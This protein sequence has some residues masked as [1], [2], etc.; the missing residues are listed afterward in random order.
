M[1]IFRKSELLGET[2]AGM[3]AR[4]RTA[5]DVI[6]VNIM[7]ADVDLNIVYMNHALR[8]FLTR[9]ET[10]IRAGLPA[11]DMATVIGSNID[12][13]HKNP[14]HQRRML[15]AMTAT[16]RTSVRIGRLVFGL[17]VTPL[18]DAAGRRIGTVVEWSDTS[19]LDHAGQVAAINRAQAVAEF[20]M[21]GTVITANA[22]F[23][24]ATGY[25]L[26]EIQGRHHGMFVDA[27]TRAGAEYA[28]LW[29]RLNQGAH[30]AGQYR[31]LG[32]QGREIWL[33]ASYT[34]ILDLTN[35]P[36]KVVKYA[37]DLT[38]RRAALATLSADVKERVR[39]LAAS[40]TEL[41]ATAESLSA[42][43]TQTSSQSAAMAGA[44]GQ[45]AVSVDEISRQLASSA[46]VVGRAVSETDSSR[47]QVSELVS[48]AD[49]IGT[50]TNVIAQIAGQTNLLALNATIEAARAGEAGK[51]FA[52]V[53]SEVKSL[54]DQTARATSEIGAQVNGI[55]NSSQSTSQV[56]RQIAGTIAK[57]NE[58]TTSIS[59]AV[60]RQAVAT[61][62]VTQHIEGVRQAAAETGRSS[63]TL[64]EV[65]QDIAAQAATLEKNISDFVAMV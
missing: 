18:L 48:T 26:D 30:V 42:A 46:Q 16:H 9:F 22:H 12:I 52:V 58:I 47:N 29:E 33:Q 37:T 36:F 24:A 62:D 57:V 32:K 53:A 60:E 17:S 3:S 35:R 28:E 25:T 1:R 50:V 64:R 31:R 61:R 7:I 2:G 44:A 13:F 49:K 23:L 38:A 63:A 56:M 54:A 15:A 59:G 14:A 43:A 27:E 4:Q 20:G 34:P 45:L 19:H 6:G 51:G 10:E 21:D 5:L 8:A 65:S 41:R 40:S 55:Q 11:F 39:A